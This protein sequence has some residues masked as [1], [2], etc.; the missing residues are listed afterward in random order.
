MRESKQVGGADGIR[1]HDLLDA[2]EARSQLRHGPTGINNFRDFTSGGWLRLSPVCYLDTDECSSLGRWPRGGRAEVRE[3]SVVRA[4]QGA[5]AE[6]DG[7]N[8]A[9]S[10][11]VG[12]A[13][14]AALRFLFDGH[15][16]DDGNSH[17]RADHA[18]KTAE[19]AAF[20]NDLRMQTRAI[21]G[22]DG[23]IAETVAVA[24]QQEGFG[25][26]IFERK[27]RAR[28]EFVFL[29][30]HGKEPLGQQWK[31]IEFVATE[32]KRQDGDVDRAGPETVE[33]DGRN[34]LDDGEPNLV[35]FARE[36]CEPRRKIV[37]SD[38][39][40]NADG[41]EAANE[42]LAFDD[43]AFGGFQFAQDGARSREKCLAK[44]G[45]PNGAAE[46]VEEARAEFIFKLEDLLGKRRLGNVRLFRGAAERA[47]F[48]HG[49]EIT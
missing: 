10:L 30:E 33:E 9:N 14:V 45:K 4:C 37:R 22:G 36:G 27:R 1:T 24:Q 35:E 6:D 18:E 39:R 26:E 41:D 47:G 13:H 25:A 3:K 11:F 44:F 8:G 16:R 43:V 15:F 46:A 23:R 29:G 7:A 49:T 48:G 32:G 40:N 17:A 5:A 2:I 20:E 19:L 21:A 12:D 31:S 38:G 34:F 42:L 28:S